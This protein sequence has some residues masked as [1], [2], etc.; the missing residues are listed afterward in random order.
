MEINDFDRVVASKAA[1]A[2]RAELD[3]SVKFGLVCPK[4]DGS[5]KD[6]D[7]KIMSD[8]I[9]AIE[10]GFAALC[11]TGRRALKDGSDDLIE[12]VKSAGID[13]EK[14]MFCA[15]DGKNT[16]KGAIFCIG[17]FCVAVGWL[18]ERGERVTAAACRDFIAA[19]CKGIC[20][21]E[22][23]SG[24]SAVTHGE[25]VFLRYGIKGAR[26]LAENG[27]N[28][29]T[30]DFL[31][32]AKKIFSEISDFDIAKTKLLAYVASKTDDVNV[33]HRSDIGT[34]KRAKAKCRRLYRDFDIGRAKRTE[35]WFVAKNVSCG[36]SADLMSLTLFLIDLGL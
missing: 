15:T 24:K 20:E 25:K 30:D 4:C 22:L 31:P 19:A 34:L 11:M 14:K 27:F 32:T 10:G 36:G 29:V 5:H 33:L 2:L 23:A 21:R 8:S 17:W 7:Y 6:I 3:T 18:T 12:S 13:T 26:G 9:D 1:N 28:V 16:H 35:R